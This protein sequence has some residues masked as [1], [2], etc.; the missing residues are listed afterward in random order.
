MSLTGLPFLLLVVAL[1]VGA[2]VWGALHVPERRR[3]AAG[4]VRRARETGLAA[5]ALTDHDTLDGVLEAQTP[6]RFEPAWGVNGNPL[7]SAEMAF[8]CQRPK[9]FC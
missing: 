7:C 5:I 9:S 2:L 3:T 1:T 4:V 6:E 8:N